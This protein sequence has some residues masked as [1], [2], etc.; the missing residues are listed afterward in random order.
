MSPKPQWEI[1]AEAKRA[2]FIKERNALT[3]VLEALGAT[4]LLSSVSGPWSCV[5]S[6]AG[7]QH[8]CIKAATGAELVAL[9]RAMQ[10]KVKP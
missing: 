10:T 8:H 3:P 7:G 2:A 5:A 4:S 9:I 1:E 6:D